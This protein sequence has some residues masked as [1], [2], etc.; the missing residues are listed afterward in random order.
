MTQAKLSLTWVLEDTSLNQEDS[1]DCNPQSQSNNHKNVFLEADKHGGFGLLLQHW[2]SLW[3]PEVYANFL[4]C[5]F[6][7]CKTD[8][9]SGGTTQSCED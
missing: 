6:L 1:D 4:Y 3:S 2:V 9:V 7:L 8:I 5:T